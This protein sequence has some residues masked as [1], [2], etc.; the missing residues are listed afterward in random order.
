MRQH[1]I[2]QNVLDVEFKLFTKFTLKE[3]AYI[4]IGVSLGGIFL[5]Y[6][7]KGSVPGIIG[8]P[9]FVIS[10]SI[11]TVLGLVPI[12]DQPADKFISNFFTAINKPTQRVWLNQEL[13]EQRDKPI[14]VKEE[15]KK[16]RVFGGGKIKVP[17]IQK[18]REKPGDDI[19]ENNKTK[20][21]TKEEQ[22]E[23]I[24]LPEGLIAPRPLDN[25]NNTIT[26]NSENISKYKF[27]VKSV[28]KLPGNIN[29]WL[30]DKNNKPIPNIK[31]SLKDNDNKLLYT[32]KTGTNGY[33]LTN[34]MY[35]EGVYNIK[36]EN[37]ED[38]IPDI[39]L[40]LNNKTDKLPLRIN[41]T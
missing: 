38:K 3:F 27:D 34:K 16:E 35:P 28:D 11:G 39:K 41:I 21:I 37:K 1:P 4:A 22:K 40:I 10:S 36:F 23:E 19:L 6:T 24:D 7:S 5:Y 32:N 14:I 33:F 15:K 2:P 18:F 12:N 13:K 8:I 26:I 25:T 29:I 9:I 17:T 31:T 20:D 30:V